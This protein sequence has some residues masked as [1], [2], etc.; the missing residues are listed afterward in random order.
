MISVF[1]LQ[2]KYINLYKQFRDYIWD[3][4]TVEMLANLEIAIFK[5]CPNIYECKNLFNTLRSNIQ[6]VILED[7]DLNEAVQDFSDLLDENSDVYCPVNII[8]E[9]IQ[10][11]D[12]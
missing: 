8:K 7:E 5:A 4:D 12:Q 9:R 11:E 2:Q 1:Q 3:Y 6:D 10:N